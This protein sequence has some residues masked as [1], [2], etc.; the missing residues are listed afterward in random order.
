MEQY[1][2]LKENCDWE[3]SRGEKERE[4]LLQHHVQLAWTYPPPSM[5]Q[6]CM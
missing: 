4:S 3:E 6:G 2:I 1:E 5:K